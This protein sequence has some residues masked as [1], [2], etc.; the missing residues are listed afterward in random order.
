MAEGFV[1]LFAW[2]SSYCIVH[3]ILWFSVIVAS[4]SL[5]VDNAK[6]PDLS[7]IRALRDNEPAANL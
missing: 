3:S 1:V 6:F 4:S 7:A 5:K 2:A